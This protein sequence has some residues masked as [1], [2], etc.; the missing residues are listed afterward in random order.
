MKQYEIVRATGTG[1]RPAAARRGTAGALAA[2]VLVLV[3]SCTGADDG[4]PDGSRTGVPRDV[5]VSPA[6]SPSATGPAGL[7]AKA[8]KDGSVPRTKITVPSNVEAPKAGDVTSDDLCG[9]LARAAAGAALGSPEDTVVRRITGNGLVTTVTLASYGNE[10]KAV[11]SLTGL[12]AAADDC[13]GGFTFRAAGREHQVT[14]AVRELAP[15]GADQ[16]MGI[17]LTERAGTGK[18]ARKVVVM[19]RGATVAVFTTTAT[20][21]ATPPGGPAVPPEVVGRQ[22]VALS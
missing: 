18:K 19:R 14:S 21:K 1:S 7:A 16:A 3:T 15:Q 9:P 22:V 13:T 10:R 5:A 4:G 20:G 2:A 6:D 11:D 12:S 8:L 17:G